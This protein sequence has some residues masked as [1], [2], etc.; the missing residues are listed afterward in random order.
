M[1]ATRRGLETSASEPEAVAALDAFTDRLARLS[2]GLDEVLEAAARHP[3]AAALQ[4]AAA[5]FFLFG[6]TAAAAAGAAEHL[7]R[8]EALAGGMNP[9]ERELLAA[10]QRWQDNDF[11]AA[12]ERLEALLTRWPRDVAALKCLEFL[13]YVTGQQHNG[14]RFLAHAEA[15]AAANRGDADVLA[16]R[17]FAAQLAGD[18]ARALAL[19]D[20][21]LAVAADNPWAH[22]AVSHALLSGG[23]RGDA[24]ARLASYLPVWIASGRVIHGHNAWHLAVAHLDQLDV[25][26]A[27]AL[28]RAHVWG[29][30][31]D[32][33]GEQIDAIALLWRIEMAGW[34][35]PDA[36]LAEVADRAEGRTAECFMP[37]LSAHHAWILARAGRRDALRSLLDTVR[38]RAARA[39]AEALRVWRPVGLAVVEA[40]AAQGSGDFIRSAAL[41]D[42]VM[43]GFTAIGG[44]DAQNDL[45]RQ[46][47]AAALSGAGRRSDARRFLGARA[48]SKGASALD[49]RL[50]ARWG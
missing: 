26:A 43:E 38:C 40:C 32:A 9:R 50:E 34:P 46:A 23:N 10:L 3:Q 18:P 25:D 13:Y 48:L 2:A 17:A 42:P 49:Q 30:D 5:S 29:F 44:S 4:L 28:H 16:V 47:Y 41:L 37:F 21:A 27:W 1:T 45:F 39:D 31:P 24:V 11:L 14:R 35:V 8:A 20:E 15:L 19:A 36:A 12:A 33:P 7:R 6:Q 22:H